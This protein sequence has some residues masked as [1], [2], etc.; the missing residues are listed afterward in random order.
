MFGHDDQQHGDNN[1]Q[2]HDDT[3]QD[4]G[5]DQTAPEP[6][7]HDG[8]LENQPTQTDAI[9]ALQEN[10]WDQ[11]HPATEQQAATPTAPVAEQHNNDLIDIKQKALEQLSPL[12]NHLDQSPEEKFNTIITM[13]KATDNKE[14]LPSAYEAAQAI[15]DEKTKAQAL[16]DIINEVNYFTQKS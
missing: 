7:M 11:Q 15:S 13:V 12:V 10:P 9:P 14:L 3:H 5:Q 6:V 4:A 8:S 2:Q 16:L 1:W